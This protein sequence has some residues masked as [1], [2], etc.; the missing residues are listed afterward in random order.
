[1]LS[2]SNSSPLRILSVDLEDWF[3]QI[4]I[5]SSADP[6]NWLNFESRIENNT[7]RLLDLFDEAQVKATFFSLGWVAAVYPRLIREIAA[8]GHDFGCHSNLHYPIHT[9]CESTFSKDLQTALGHLEDALGQKITSFRAPGFSLT[10]DCAWALPVLSS[11]GI[12]CDASFFAGKHAHGGFPELNIQ[13]PFRMLY[14]GTEILELPASTLRIGPIALS[15]TGGGYFR[16]LPYSLIQKHIS[17]Q[18]YIMSYVHPRD[19]DPDQPTLS[20]LSLLRKVKSRVGLNRGIVKLARLIRDYEWIP[21]SK[22][23][24][25]IQIE[26]LP[27]YTIQ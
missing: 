3:H 26:T 7:Y 13:V 22:A 12:T 8:R 18:P 23:I 2:E 5:A 14:G 16:L 4:G 24:D 10:R 11:H 25:H 27:Q 15:P 9:L 17:N 20:D 19:F 21:I 1:M 6:A